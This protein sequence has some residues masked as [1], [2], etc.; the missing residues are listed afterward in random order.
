MSR[1][2]GRLTMAGRRPIFMA[3]P[4]RTLSLSG[5]QGLP[6]QDPAAIG[7]VRHL[8]DSPEVSLVNF[9]ARNTAARS[10]AVDRGGTLILQVSLR[11]V[12][13][14]RTVSVRV[15]GLVPADS[16]QP[17]AVM[18]IAGRLDEH[19]KFITHSQVRKHLLKPFSTRRSFKLDRNNFAVRNSPSYIID[20]SLNNL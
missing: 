13:L 3:T 18:G 20:Q 5:L 9:P 4:I 11:T 12:L 2:K 7:H 17:F 15:A 19:R 14:L 10:L 8:L 6:Q 1:Y 16:H